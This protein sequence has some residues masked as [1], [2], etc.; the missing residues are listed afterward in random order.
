MI[1]TEEM[2]NT[3]KHKNVL[4]VGLAKSGT[5]V[6]NLL[7]SFGAKVSITDTKPRRYL[8]TNIK[9]LLPSINVI[10][11][12]NPEGIFETADLIVV[13]PGVPLNIPSLVHAKTRGIPVIGELELAYQV[14]KSGVKELPTPH[15]IGVT[16]TNGKSTTTTLID[17]MLRKSGFRTMLGG[18]I[19]NALTEEII[20]IVRGQSP[21]ATRR[22]GES[23]VGSQESKMEDFKLSTINSR[24][25]MT[26]YIVAEISSF[27]LESIKEFRPGIAAILNITPDHLDRYN[28]MEEYINAKAMIFENQRYGDCLILN[29]DD[30][31]VKKVESEKLKVKREK[32]GVFYFS[33]NKEVEGVYSKDGRIYCNFPDS[34][35]VTARLSLPKSRPS[36]LMDVDEIKI[37]GVHNLENAMA[38]SAVAFI[39]GCS[40]RGIRDVL[41]DFPGLEHRLEFAGEVNG[42]RFINDSKGTNAGAV[43]KSIESF[44]N[45]ILIMGGMDKKS[46]FSVLQDLIRK[47][48]KALILFGEAKEKIAGAIGGLTEIL[49]VNDIKEAV[50]FSMSRALSGDVVLLSPGCASFDM[51]TDFEDRGR[52]FKEAVSLMINEQLSMDS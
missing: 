12:G 48:V 31:V 20:K 46:D 11:D 30:P 52:K 15:F 13:S 22:G 33:C 51:F 35:P 26:D 36:P 45:I 34:L 7:S 8:E 25:T 29:A 28:T 50:K 10:T 38:A 40:W 42:V 24:F 6:A 9:K 43:I 23:G 14:I 49:I 37:K 44:K 32:P 27:Q 41:K 39:S 3:F 17:L 5:G 4:V 16:G 19:G 2:K 1:Q 18:N 47:K 21:Q